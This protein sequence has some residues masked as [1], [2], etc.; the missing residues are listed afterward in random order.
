M[1]YPVARV[2]DVCS[3]RK[4]KKPHSFADAQASGSRPY[5]LIE[6]F[7]G[8]PTN[9]AG[10]TTCAL[11]DQDDTLLVC[12]GANTGLSST[13]HDG[14][15]GSTLAAL[16]PD[17]S[18][19][20]P[21]FLYHFI[22]SRFDVLNTRVRGAAIPHLERELMLNMPLV[23]PPLPE[24]KRIVRI[25]DEAEELRRLRAEADRRT[26]DVIPAIFY[27]MFG[28]PKYIGRLRWPR[29]RVDSFAE[30][31]YGLADKL[32]AATTASKGTRIITISN[33]ALNGLLDLNAT[34]RLIQAKEPKQELVSLI[35]CSIGGT[36]ANNTW[37]RRRYGKARF[38]ERFCTSRSC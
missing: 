35:F 22:S 26:A 3:F 27:D 17:R 6:S 18:R 31:S 30:V 21:K 10:D 37:E 8:T 34:Q 16:K 38:L 19:I 11:C 29:H 13:G 24:Q 1:K 14:Y 12:D 4:G 23:L 2:R 25:L 5:I 33:V 32:D 20:E 9:Y 15:V 7:S 28:D 36:A